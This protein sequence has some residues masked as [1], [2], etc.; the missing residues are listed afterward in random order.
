MKDKDLG[1]ALELM[2]T[3]EICWVGKPNFNFEKPEHPI[4]SLIEFIID[5]ADI[6][7][8][9]GIAILL[10]VFYAKEFLEI[11]DVLFYPVF[12]IG[13]ILYGIFWNYLE[14]KSTQN[15][16]YILTNRRVVFQS[17][18]LFKGIQI[19]SLALDKIQKLSLEEF[20]NDI[21]T[22]YF[23]GEEVREYVN[24]SLT[25]GGSKFY[26]TFEIVEDARGLMPMMEE[27]I[28]QSRK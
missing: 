21:G 13:F 28:R 9:I 11:K 2:P 26:P 15:R 27:L 4:W 17:W 25:E 19:H 6:L 7:I 24:N 23:M 18:S 12:L 14:R 3:E 22:I 16:K 5:F 1:I 8:M 10:T 20:D